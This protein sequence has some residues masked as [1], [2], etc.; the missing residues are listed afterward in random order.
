[1][2]N[3]IAHIC[4]ENSFIYIT[5]N[6]TEQCTRHFN[7]YTKINRHYDCARNRSLVVYG[8]VLIVFVMIWLVWLVDRED[9]TSDLCSSHPSSC[10]VI[11]QISVWVV[12]ETWA[13]ETPT[14]TPSSHL[15]TCVIYTTII[16]TKDMFIVWL[17]LLLVSSVHLPLARKQIWGIV[18]ILV[19]SFR[20]VGRLLAGQEKY[21]V[22]SGHFKIFV[23]H[24][25]IQPHRIKCTNIPSWYYSFV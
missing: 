4:L 19:V 16:W 3:A 12:R 11:I 8:T 6:W 20:V 17:W 14:A 25:I 13:V 2:N 10:W 9:E 23:V 7:Y 22:Q 21:K 15:N 1:M 5:V 24:Y 18:K